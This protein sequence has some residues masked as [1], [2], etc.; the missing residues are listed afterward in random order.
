MKGGIELKP[1]N[2]SKLLFY[3]KEIEDVDQ[4][5]RK[6]SW[7]FNNSLVIVNRLYPSLHPSY[8][9]LIDRLAGFKCKFYTQ[10]GGKISL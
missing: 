2:R 3:F 1:L 10:T 6:S 5:L 7:N 8:M 4:V 9:F